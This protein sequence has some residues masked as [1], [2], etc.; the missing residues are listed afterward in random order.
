MADAVVTGQV[1]QKYGIHISDPEIVGADLRAAWGK[2]F[3]CSRHTLDPI[4]QE[5]IVSM[6]DRGCYGLIEDWRGEIRIH[7]PDSDFLTS[8]VLLQLAA[9]A[10][11]EEC[12]YQ[13]DVTAW[14]V[15]WTGADEVA[16]IPH[17]W[18]EVIR[19]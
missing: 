15:R 7:I 11:S 18:D 3:K 1:A 10:A 9:E 6:V 16:L 13:V 8:P 14:K 12:C 19:G 17:E 4:R 5:V 2:S